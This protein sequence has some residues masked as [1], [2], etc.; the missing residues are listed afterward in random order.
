MDELEYEYFPAVDNQATIGGS[1]LEA[2]TIEDCYKLAKRLGS[3][4]FT[5][6]P[7]HLNSCS[8][9]NG[10]SIWSKSEGSKSFLSKPKPMRIKNSFDAPRILLEVF[11]IVLVCWYFYT[12]I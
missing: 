3:F 7:S 10:A 1:E 12:K 11:V 5:W 9:V 6:T 4:G 2:K 8:T